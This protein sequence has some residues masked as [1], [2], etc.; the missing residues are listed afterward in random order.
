MALRKAC[1]GS[2][3]YLGRYADEYTATPG[4]EAKWIG[5]MLEHPRVFCIGA[6]SEGML[7]GV[8]WTIPQAL[9][10]MAHR[11][12][13]GIGVDES[14]RGMGVGR[15]LMEDLVENSKRTDLV[16]L[17]LEVAPG[18]KPAVKLYESLGFRKVGSMP[19]AMRLR[20]G[21]FLDLDDMVL[22]LRP[23]ASR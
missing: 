6:F 5:M 15:A 11:A 16:Q 3:D 20:D 18:N 13:I 2:T 14:A 9:P 12:L 22:D 17:E 10:K 8:V 19:R 4:D 23:Q 1:Y 21:S 7:L